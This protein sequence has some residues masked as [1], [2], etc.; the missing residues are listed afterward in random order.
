MNNY[1]LVTFAEHSHIQVALLLEGKFDDQLKYEKLVTKVM[2][3]LAG[4]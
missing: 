3:D 1:D 4:D 2:S